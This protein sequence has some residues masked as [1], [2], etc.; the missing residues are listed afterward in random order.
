MRK[1]LHKAMAILKDN[2]GEALFESIVSILVF[3]IL[4][5]TVSLVI[6]VALGI[7]ANANNWSR[8]M[9][10]ESNATML[11]ESVT[12]PS[13]D[14]IDIIVTGNDAVIALSITVDDTPGSVPV[15][16]DIP[17]TVYTSNMQEFVSFE[18]RV[19]SGP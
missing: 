3:T 9:Q 19:P 12:L 11:G 13:P 6:L 15:N 14:N 1:F 8:R 18:Q 10:A 2:R 17:I 4:L 16:L 5:V 7:T